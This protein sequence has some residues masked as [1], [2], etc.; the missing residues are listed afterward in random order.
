MTGV[1]KERNMMHNKREGG[2]SAL[3][4]VGRGVTSL[5]KGHV[6]RDTEDKKNS[7]YKE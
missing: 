7:A 6:G 1:M 2:S 5:Q 3:G 4:R